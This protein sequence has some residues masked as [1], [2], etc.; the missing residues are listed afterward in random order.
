MSARKVPNGQYRFPLVFFEL[1][2]PE[3]TP[4][5]GNSLR[6]PTESALSVE[7]PARFAV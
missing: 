4:S 5:D 3:Y 1:S 2:K 6:L 7:I